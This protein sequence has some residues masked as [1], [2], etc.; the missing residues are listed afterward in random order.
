MGRKESNQTNKNLYLRYETCDW[1]WKDKDKRE[2]LT[3]DKARYLIVR[4][5]EKN[6]VAF[7]HF[8]F[9]IEIDEEVLYW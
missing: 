8:R 7:V 9:D 5:Q 1:G 6:P 2:E 3:E 4:D